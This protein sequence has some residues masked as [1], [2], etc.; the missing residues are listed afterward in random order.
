MHELNSVVLK[1]LASSPWRRHFFLCH[2]ILEWSLCFTGPRV[3]LLGPSFGKVIIVV[4]LIG[5]QTCHADIKLY[6]RYNAERSC[7]KHC[8]QQEHSLQTIPTG[9]VFCSMENVPPWLRLVVCSL[10]E[11][12]VAPKHPEAEPLVR[13][14]AIAGYCRARPK[15]QRSLATALRH[16][17]SHDLISPVCEAPCYESDGMSSLPGA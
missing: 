15:K 17:V 10:L 5:V 13:N 16:A 11:H 3:V 2:V 1:E 12:R 4:V 14:L 7:K 9:H 8:R 6:I